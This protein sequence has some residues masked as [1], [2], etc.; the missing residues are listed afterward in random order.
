LTDGADPRIS[1]DCHA[2]D[3]TRTYRTV[4]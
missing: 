2:A 4:N 3:M 1:D